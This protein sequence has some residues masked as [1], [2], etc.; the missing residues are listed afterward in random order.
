M[1]IQLSEQEKQGWTMKQIADELSVNKMRVYRTISRLGLTEA[2]KKGQTLYFD[3]EAKNAVES[4][5]R[6][7]EPANAK[8]AS[9]PRQTNRSATENDLLESLNDRVKAQ[10][11]QIETLTRLLD[12]SQRL[13]LV[14]E[15]RTQRVEKQ[16]TELQ[17]QISTPSAVATLTRAPQSNERGQLDPDYFD[18]DQAEKQQVDNQGQS[19]KVKIIQKPEKEDGNFFKHFWQKPML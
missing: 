12:Q 16:V 1:V 10:Q 13:Q 7:T 3:Q 18:K 5:I 15:Q 11:T 17:Q 14:A 4:A 19:S 2:F 6:Q 9:Q 8:T